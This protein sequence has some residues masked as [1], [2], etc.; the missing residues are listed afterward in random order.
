MRTSTKF[1]V[2][3]VT[4]V[5]MGGLWGLNGCKEPESATAETDSV[6]LCMK[7]GQIKDSALCCQPNQPKCS[8]CGLVKGSPGCCNIPKGAK[9]AALCTKCGQIKG[10]ALCC[11]AGQAK[12]PACG[13]VKGS[14]G[15]CKIP[16][17]LKS[18]VDDKS[19]PAEQA[20]LTQVY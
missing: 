9:T 14:P 13:L 10:S 18:T 3:M 1:Q 16:K 6:P 12:C 5:L 8:S 2:M 11:K 15:C 7:C 20:S 19:L 17:A 4:I